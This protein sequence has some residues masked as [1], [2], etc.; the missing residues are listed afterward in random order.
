MKKIQN[1]VAVTPL[2]EA[3]SGPVLLL[4]WGMAIGVLLWGSGIDVAI[5]RWLFANY[6]QG[7]N[8]V[9]RVLGEIGKGTAQIV[10]C[11]L[12]AGLW[13]GYAWWQGK[14]RPAGARLIVMAI[15]VFALAGI[16][17]FIMKWCIGRGRPKEFLLNGGDPYAM[18]PFAHDAQWWSFPSGHSCSTFAIVVWL[19]L[20]FPR[21]RYPLWAVGI[22]L[23]MSRFLA[24]TPH[25]AGDVVAGA[26]V[27][28][29]VAWAVWIVCKQR[30]NGVRHG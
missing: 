30:G 19:G 2:A 28:A 7:F 11:L 6:V 14:V 18:Q 22:V 26:A 27:G 3:L 25:F 8:D 29:A 21:W 16:V 23:S 5:Q 9:M 15:P 20:V 17:N 10:M 12:V 13:F 24:V 1:P 4:V